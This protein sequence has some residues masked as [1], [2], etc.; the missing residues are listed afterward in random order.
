MADAEPMELATVD[1]RHADNPFQSACP[2]LDN[3]HPKSVWTT[4]ERESLVVCNHSPCDHTIKYSRVTRLYVT[5]SAFVLPEVGMSVL[6]RIMARLSSR[7]AWMVHA[8]L[9]ARVAKTTRVSPLS[10]L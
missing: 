1:R 10:G 8:S 6:P 5:A 9:T 7:S 3:R 4:R 2:E